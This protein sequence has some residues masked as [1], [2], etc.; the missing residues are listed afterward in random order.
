MSTTNTDAR[1]DWTFTTLSFLASACFF[2]ASATKGD[3][4]HLR[5]IAALLFQ[6]AG[7]LGLWS[8]RPRRAAQSPSLADPAH[9]GAPGA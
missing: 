7:F 9:Q 6:A 4:H 3:S 1:H 8:M 2:V 5:L